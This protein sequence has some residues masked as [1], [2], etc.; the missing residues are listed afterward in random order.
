MMHCEQ[1]G[2]TRGGSPT[3]NIF[4]LGECVEEAF[5]MKNMLVVVSVDFRKAYDSVKSEMLI[6]ILMDYKVDARIIDIVY[7]I[8]RSDKTYINMEGEQEIEMRVTSG[9]RQG[10]T[11]S[12]VLFK[13][14]TF[15]LIEKLKMTRGVNI[16]TRKI[17]CLFYADDGLLLANSVEQAE[18]S[19]KIVREEGEKYGLVINENKSKCLVFNSGMTIENIEN[20]NVMEKL[21]YLG[22][23]VTSKRD[24]FD[25]QR[26]AMM[27]KMQMMS[28]MTNS[29]IEK[30]CHRTLII[31]ICI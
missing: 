15:K 31:P 25:G 8:Y 23:T 22:V 16:G 21:K 24:L 17:T 9:I 5:R 4:I 18:K 28:Y 2:F 12:S 1:I 30:R 3:D 26:Q 27:E 11:A 29:I 10:C 14:L 19:I 13:L 20:I 7:R 6:R